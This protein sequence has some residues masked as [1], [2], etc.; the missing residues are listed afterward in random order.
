LDDVR[1][2]VETNQVDAL[3]RRAYEVDGPIGLVTVLHVAA[4]LERIACRSRLG[5]R[6]IR[7]GRV[8]SDDGGAF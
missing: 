8:L 1:A 6:V 7:G 2:A 3:M 4:N 5:L